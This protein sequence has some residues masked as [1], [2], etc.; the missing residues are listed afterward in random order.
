MH[1]INKSGEF[2]KSG[3]ISTKAGK[4]R[5]LLLQYSTK[6]DWSWIYG[7]DILKGDMTDPGGKTHLLV[8]FLARRPAFSTFKFIIDFQSVGAICVAMLVDKGI[9]KYGDRVE[10][11]WPSYGKNGKEDTTIE[12]VLEHRVGKF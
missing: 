7:A 4:R 2:S 3:E 6:V 8:C 1:F 12:M 10:K 9:C 5:A 11:Y